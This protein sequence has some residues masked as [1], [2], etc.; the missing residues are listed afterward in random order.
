MNM[1]AWINNEGFVDLLDAIASGEHDL[2]TYCIEHD[3]LVYRV[4]SWIHADPERTEAYM[5]AMSLLADA[6]VSRTRRL[7]DKPIE[8][9][10]ELNNAYFV[11]ATMHKTAKYYQTEIE[12]SRLVIQARSRAAQISAPV[13]HV[14]SVASTVP[15][16]QR[17][18]LMAPPDAANSGKQPSAKADG[19]P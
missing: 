4:L 6:C 5:K 16:D 1:E 17:L 19:E 10:I 2:H 9:H 18:A 3:L 14:Q 7:A 8:T 13:I 11:A 15:Y 12:R